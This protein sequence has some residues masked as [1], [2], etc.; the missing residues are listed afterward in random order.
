MRMTWSRRRASPAASVDRMHFVMWDFLKM[1]FATVMCGI[2]VSLVAA[3]IALVLANDANAA[4]GSKNA[5]AANTT[6]AA[7]TAEHTDAPLPAPGLLLIGTGCD[8]AA[9]EAI[10]R[11]WKVT[12]SR[13]YIDVRV[14]QTFIMPEGDSTAATFIAVLPAGATLHRLNAH[15]V[16]SLWQGNVFDAP[17]YRQLTDVDFRNSARAGMLIVQNDDGI[18]SADAIINITATEA[19]TI[20]YS[21]RV[22]PAQFETTT[23]LAVATTNSEYQL[24]GGDITTAGTVWVE[25]VGA[26]PSRLTRM[27]GGASVE[28]VGSKITGLSWTTR[29]LTADAPF[30]L[31]WSM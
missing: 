3:G 18:I 5:V 27:P 15:T 4:T 16:G 8:A 17:S 12:I 11:D 23:T 19:V 1:F 26:N 7:S 14:M 31:A 10:E 2:A 13:K 29:Q 20:E 9:V 24:D 30:Q 22:S 28:T 21:Y 25:W 6:P